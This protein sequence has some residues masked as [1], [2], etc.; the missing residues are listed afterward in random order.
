MT[1]GQVYV[2]YSLNPVA[3]MAGCHKRNCWEHLVPVAYRNTYNPQCDFIKLEIQY[4][5]FKGTVTWLVNDFPVHTQYRLG[6]PLNRKYRVVEY[7]GSEYSL[8]TP[9]KMQLQVGI[10]MM[11]D[12]F[13]Y[14]EFG[15]V[16]YPLMRYLKEDQYISPEKG[17][18]AKVPEAKEEYLNGN[19]VHV[20]FKYLAITYTPHSLDIS[21]CVE[22][23]CDTVEAFKDYKKLYGVKSSVPLL[24]KKK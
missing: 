8:I 16:S 13:Y 11:P 24:A 17:V 7:T 2:R 19:E 15:R 3:R 9:K 4:D 5:Y 18:Y 22:K 12:A 10:G 21:G 6:F 14:D 20:C 23:D 1:N